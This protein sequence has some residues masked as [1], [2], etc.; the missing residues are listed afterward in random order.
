[1]IRSYESWRLAAFLEHATSASQADVADYAPVRVLRRRRLGIEKSKTRWWHS[2]HHNMSRGRGRGFNPQIRA[3]C[4]PSA[5]L[6]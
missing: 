6:Q 1:M 4:M 3:L 2:R 5:R